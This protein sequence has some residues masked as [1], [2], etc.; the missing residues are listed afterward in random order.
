M[1]TLPK[2]KRVSPSVVAKQI[3]AVQPMAGPIGNIFTMRATWIN[4][5]DVVHLGGTRFRINCFV[6]GVDPILEHIW[7]FLSE[8]VHTVEDNVVTFEST[9]IA[10]EFKLRFC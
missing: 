1:T 6:F 10:M 5:P 3:I 8:T 4:Q 7:K 9:K 2:V